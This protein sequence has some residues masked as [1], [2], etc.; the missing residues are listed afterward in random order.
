VAARLIDKWR[1]AGGKMKRMASEIKWRMLRV[2]IIAH[3]K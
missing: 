1:Q 3:K 2:G